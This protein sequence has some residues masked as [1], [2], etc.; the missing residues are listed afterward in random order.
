MDDMDLTIPPRREHASSG[1]DDV[2]MP[3]KRDRKPDGRFDIGDLIMRRYKVLAELGQGG[4]G[5]V[6]KCFDETAG[7]EVALKALPPEL[8]HNT[9]EMEDIKDNFQLVHNLHHPNIASS[10][11]LEKDNSNGNYY[12]IMECCE[13]E[14]LRRWLRRKRKEGE[15]TLD[16]ILP[17]VKQVADALDYAHKM[18]IIHRDIKPGNI[19]INA[20]GEIKVL[21]FGLAAQI[22][23]SMTRV[24]MAYYGTSGT[25]PY[26]APEQWEGRLQDAKADQYAL[27]VMTYEML[28]GHPPFESTDAAVLREAVLKSTVPPLA[29]VPKSAEAAILR[30]MSKE[31]AERFES[32]SD[33]AAALG[34]KK[35]KSAKIQKKGGSGKWIAAALVVILLGGI[36][37]YLSGK[38]EQKPTVPP[39]PV[40]NP[41]VVAP[42]VVPPPKPAPVPDIKPAPKDEKKI[43]QETYRLQASVLSKKRD[44]ESANH[45]QEQSFGRYLKE[46]K[47]NYEAGELALK[48]ND[49]TAANASFKEA[50]KAA[51][52]IN[53][54]APLRREVQSLQK[55]V[56]NRKNEADKFNASKLSLEIYNSASAK[57]IQAKKDYESGKF[58]P[59]VTAL[60]SA[61]EEFRKAYTESR[62]LTLDNLIKSAERAKSNRQWKKLKEKAQEI[63]PLDPGKAEEFVQYANEQ[64]KLENLNKELSAARKAKAENNWQSVCDHAVAALK[65]DSSNSEAQSLKQEA[66]NHL[67]PTLEI[68]ATVDGKRVPA[69]VQFGSQSEK[70]YN[71]IFRN[72]QENRRYRGSLSYQAGE[73]EYV[74]D[75]EFVCNWRGPRKMT[76]ALKKQEFT[77]IDCNG[78]TL[79]MVKIKAGTF[80]M[81]SPAG[82]LGRSNDEQQH[83]V[84]LTQD[85]WLGKFEVT[86]T[87]WQALMGNNPSNYKGDDRPVEQVSWN[88][89]KEFCNKLNTIYAGKLPAGYKFDLPTEAQWEYACRAGTTTALNNGKNLTDEKYNCENLAEVAWYDYQN[90]ENQTHP[91]GQKRPNNWGLYDMHGNVWEWCRDWYGSYNGDAVDPVGPSS[92]SFRVIR[93]GS[94]NYFA[95]N[96]RSA[97]RSY[98]SP[99]NRNNDLGFRLALV[100]SR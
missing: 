76:V 99:G 6:Y 97:D 9:L 8:S 12:L 79:E 74:G 91:I 86:Q 19:M 36:G 57:E 43:R 3:G 70:T 80:T 92:G 47:E 49:V 53:I 87:Q 69:T 95:R 7:I 24:S 39:V 67:I 1:A 35:V 54:N 59:A 10:N 31:P 25:G 78:V 58:P 4:M 94:W 41:P 42:A 61:L 34:G 68:I 40:V 44:I 72:L 77:K 83:Q 15:L 96:C 52:W 21:D 5:V 73:A 33:F 60:K 55:E 88:D 56:N 29:N 98:D 89:A 85:Y 22:H 48:N 17:I 37:F 62:N 20:A 32:C 45:D 71:N 63:S 38:E 27:A 16:D 18:K 14:D 2:T 23:T 84:T 51:D 30:A 11:T 28:A 90:K 50:E 100:P 65:I 66:E 26:M 82:E 93:G 64:I 13:G 81:G 75:I 46:L